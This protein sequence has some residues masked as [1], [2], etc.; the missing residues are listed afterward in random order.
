MVASAAACLTKKAKL[1]ATPMATA[2]S[3]AS[4]MSSSASAKRASIV[5]TNAS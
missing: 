2:A 5:A 4:C 1:S 3:A